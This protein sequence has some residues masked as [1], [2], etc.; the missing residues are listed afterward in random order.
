MVTVGGGTTTVLLLLLLPPLV[1]RTTPA[2]TAAALA[3]RMILNVR[4]DQKLFRLRVFWTSSTIL[5]TFWIALGS[6]V[7]VFPDTLD[8]LADR[9]RVG[10]NASQYLGG[11]ALRYSLW[12]SLRSLRAYYRG[13]ER[14]Y[15]CR[16]SEF[17]H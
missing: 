15:D 17:S 14:E 7:A 13:C 11:E 10:R 5:V 12:N 3:T 9:R 16:I 4:E 8:R 6:W 1:A 2:A